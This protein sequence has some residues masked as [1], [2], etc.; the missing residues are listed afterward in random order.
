MEMEERVRRSDVVDGVLRTLRV[1]VD[2]IF[3]YI[4]DS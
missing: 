4:I 1:A 2:N 3:F